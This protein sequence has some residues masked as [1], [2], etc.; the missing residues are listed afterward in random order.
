M[1][2]PVSR[3][4]FVSGTKF[5]LGEREHKKNKKFLSLRTTA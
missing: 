5:S 1:G 3:I 4:A 2:L